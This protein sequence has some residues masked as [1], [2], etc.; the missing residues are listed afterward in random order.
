MT[1]VAEFAIHYAQ[2]IDHQ[3][4]ATQPLPEWAQ[5]S[6]LLIQL[7]QSM[8]LTRHMDAKAIALQRTGRLGTYPSVLGQEA[9]SCAIGHALKQEDVFIPYYRDQGAQLQ[10]GVKI[11]DLYR[12]WGGDEAGSA[13]PDNQDFPI[14]IPIASQCLHASGVATAFKLKNEAR[15]ALVSC[16]DGAT[17]E[18]D[19]YEAMNV[20]GVWTLPVVFVVNNNQ[21]AISVA[22]KQQTAT[23]TLAQKAIAAGIHGE[24]IDG[25]DVVAVY[26]RI[27]QALRR[28]RQGKGAS[29]IEAITYRLS[30]HTTA[31]DAT[32]YRE[33]K[34]TKEAW[35]YEPISRLRSY[36]QHQK[37]WDEQ[38]EKSPASALHAKSK[39]RE[40]CLSSVSLSRDR[41]YV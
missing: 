22:R 19:F 5:D 34:E 6:Q 23:K 10:R 14:S 13:V 16:G 21:W 29:L 41:R 1:I 36:M 24:Q 39:R 40:R 2:F 25:N 30:D 4:Q 15:V 35:A 7:Y 9:I 38:Q 37:W 31:D 18:G 32:R 12:Y 3:G 33:T 8:C 11:E 20:A 26:E 28:A 17:S 27:H